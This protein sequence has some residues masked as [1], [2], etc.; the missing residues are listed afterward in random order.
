[1]KFAV[2]SAGGSKTA[3]VRQAFDRSPEVI[4][5]EEGNDR[6]GVR[7]KFKL[8]DAGNIYHGYAMT[9]TWMY[10]TGEM[11]LTAAACF[12][13]SIVHTAVTDAR[14]TVQLSGKYDSV[15]PG[16]AAERSVKLTSRQ[17]L[18][19]T[20]TALPGR[21]ISVAGR[22]RKP[23]SFYWRTGKMEPFSW[24]GRRKFDPS[25]IGAPSYYRWPT[26]LPQAFPKTFTG[27]NLASL[28][29]GPQEI[30][31]I[32]LD[33][34]PSD[35][36][37]PTFT[38]LLRIASP[39][40]V[41]TVKNYVAHEKNPVGIEVENG[42]I[43]ADD[44]NQHGYVDNEG[45]YQIRKTGNPLTMTLPSDAAQ[46]TVRVKIICLDGYGAVVTK[47]E[48]KPVVPHLV[49]EGG[50]V[51]DPLAP[52]QEA[53]EGPADMA[54]VTV[55]LTDRPQKLTVSEEDGIQ[56]AYQTR[57]TW[58][59]VMCF[60]SETGKRHSAFR[61]SLVDGRARNIRKYGNSEWA[62]TEN[63]LTWFK[64]CGQSPI[65][66]IDNISDF[67]IIKNGPDEA[68]FYYKSV[69]A[70]ERAQSEYTV[71]VPA[72]SPALQL[73]VST[74]FSV[75]KYWP[76]STNQFFDV[77]PFRGV[78]PREWWYDS[79]LWLTPDGRTKWEDTH[80]WQFEGDKSLAS[81]TGNGFFALCSS[82]RGNMVMLNKNFSPLLPVH[83]V[84][85]GNYIDFHMDVHFVDENGN[86]KQPEPGFTMSMEYDL[87]LWGDKNTTREELIDMGKKSLRAGKLVFP[88]RRASR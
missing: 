9:E 27:Y 19:F 62:L 42:V 22:D 53:S 83:Y 32:W 24:P 20:D 75:L 36:A 18:V 10:P 74:R 34:K 48:G 86:P 82:D 87:A 14:L 17:T 50:I 25:A 44:Q 58:R 26:Y 30:G 55:R 71:R 15:T 35:T 1:M 73:N 66:M 37:N 29:Y 21:Y 23:L 68:I 41:Q 63:L 8:F 72:D 39:G 88:E 85:C 60:S 16:T 45:V 38:A 28:E 79:V 6:T 33:N 57:D 51:D 56:F 13:D 3:E 47:L 5:I 81:I 77:F 7:I 43:F 76:Y 64:N 11:Y 84:I 61:F 46:R 80:T 31:F 49:S 12:E 2:T 59:N 67:R 52:I 54:L 69:N 65:D 40:D 70:N 78:D 4:F